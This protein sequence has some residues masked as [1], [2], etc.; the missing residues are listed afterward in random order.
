MMMMMIICFV[1]YPTDHPI[2]TA[3]IRPCQ[4]CPV[5]PIHPFFGGGGVVW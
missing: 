4:L 2:A 5:V 1:F 3:A